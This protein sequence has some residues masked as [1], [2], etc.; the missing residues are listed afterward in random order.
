MSQ[1]SVGIKHR[2]YMSLTG[3][4]FK[5]LIRRVI[6]KDRIGIKIGAS[7]SF[8]INYICSDIGKS[9][10]NHISQLLRSCCKS[11]I[12][13]RIG[14]IDKKSIDCND[15][16]NTLGIFRKFLK[17]LSIYIPGPCTVRTNLVKCFVI[18]AD[19]DY[20]SVKSFRRLIPCI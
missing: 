14:F 13:I 7:G 5:C 10:R 3:N 20:L 2:I 1:Y 18:D 4:F 11:G 12:C 9:C 6:G 17:C 15:C 8:V 16:R 19:D